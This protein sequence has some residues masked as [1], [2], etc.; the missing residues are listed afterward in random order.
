MSPDNL[1]PS[2][3]GGETTTAHTGFTETQRWE[4]GLQLLRLRQ[5]KSTLRY[6]IQF[7]LISNKLNWDER[8]LIAVFENGLKDSV[9]DVIC[10]RD[11]PATLEEYITMAVRIDNRLYERRQEKRAMK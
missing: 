4:Y 1:R 3:R 10:L 9:K 8:V 6:S 2:N 11:R 5:K 7:K